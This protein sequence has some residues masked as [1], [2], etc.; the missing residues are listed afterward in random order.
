MRRSAINQLIENAHRFAD[1]L[2]FKL[3][4]FAYWTPDEWSQKGPEAD[5]IR[6]NRLGWDVTDFGKGDFDRCGLT[7][8]TI[9]NGN[10]KN[11]TAPDMVA[12]TYCEKLLIVGEDQ[13]T[14]MHFHWQK[15]EDIINRGGGVLVIKLY[16]ASKEEAL[17][18]DPVRVSTDGV[19]RE[20]PAGTDIRLT[21]GESITLPPCLY[22][23]FWAE[24][25][26]GPV[27]AG[28][29]SAV[30]DDERDN[31]FLEPLGRFPAIEEDEPSRFLL[32]N[33][34]PAAR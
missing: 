34:Y 17:S 25:G 22:H 6:T 11:A 13:L 30:N 4:P 2:Q 9:R 29:V 32:C 16:N 12:K 7:L 10:P 24:K 19:I 26:A 20:V 3:P 31:R 18:D 21:P 27:L 33:E 23:A 8:F 5:E 28:E 1:G 14:P 15:M